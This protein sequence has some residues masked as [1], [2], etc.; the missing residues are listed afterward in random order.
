M[1][2]KPHQQK[3]D[4]DN[5]VKAVLDAVHTDDSGIYHFEA[6]K[7]WGEAGEIHIETIKQPIQF[8]STLNSVEYA[9]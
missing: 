2:G 1:S 8:H 6:M 9:V 5:L 3:P 7:F 4:T